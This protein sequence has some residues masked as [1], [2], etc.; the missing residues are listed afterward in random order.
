MKLKN[1]L[2]SKN[3]ERIPWPL[4]PGFLLY[5]VFLTTVS[6]ANF[7]EREVDFSLLQ[8]KS[9]SGKT[10]VSIAFLWFPDQKYDQ[11]VLFIP[12]LACILK[13]PARATITHWHF[14]KQWWPCK[15]KISM[16]QITNYTGHVLPCH[17][18]IFSCRGCW[19]LTSAKQDALLKSGSVSVR[20][21]SIIGRLIVPILLWCLTLNRWELWMG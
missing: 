12:N 8:K 5:L 15:E 11:D 18:L 14:R 2:Y 20:K 16:K 1:G 19:K 7:Q 21:G 10:R 3:I 17:L 13:I 9:G 6:S 4:G